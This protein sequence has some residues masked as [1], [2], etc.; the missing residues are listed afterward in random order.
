MPVR[1]NVSSWG[2]EAFE[3]QMVCLES[4]FAVGVDKVGCKT[5]LALG[6]GLGN[7]DSVT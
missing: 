1:S 5:A 7:S 4:Y 6:G 2:K 3:S